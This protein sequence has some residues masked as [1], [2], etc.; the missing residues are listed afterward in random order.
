[1]TKTEQNRA[2]ITESLDPPFWAGTTDTWPRDVQHV[3]IRLNR[4]KRIRRPYSSNALSTSLW[5]RSPA[6]AWQFRMTV[7]G[8]KKPGDSVQLTG[9]KV[10][11]VRFGQ[12]RANSTRQYQAVPVSRLQVTSGHFRSLHIILAARVMKVTTGPRHWWIFA[13]PQATAAA[14]QTARRRSSVASLL[15]AAQAPCFFLSKT[16]ATQLL[17]TPALTFDGQEHRRHPEL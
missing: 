10:F 14:F 1:M 7:F 11:L 8:Q 9:A 5:N 17:R 15:D 12:C 2:S 6:K 16:E 13:L 3:V 4:A